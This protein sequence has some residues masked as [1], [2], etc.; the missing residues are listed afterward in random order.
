MTS[1][2]S[3][4]VEDLLLEWY[5]WQERQSVAE[6]LAHWYDAAD[7][8][9]REHEAEYPDSDGDSDRSEAWILASK[10][11]QVQLCVD[12]LPVTQR[13]ALQVT[14]RNKSLGVAVWSNGRAGD[15]HANY[16]AA[17][18]ALLPM[19][20]AKR[21]IRSEDSARQEMAPRNS[22]ACSAAMLQPC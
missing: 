5:R 15:A 2:E 13:A 3:A 22:A 12:E 9:C 14:L 17:K 18:C 11:E 8:T 20:R 10:G 19:L 6:V 21:L 1:N 16:Q 7:G 4:E